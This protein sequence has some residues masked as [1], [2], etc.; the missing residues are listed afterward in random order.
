M[1][2][3]SGSFPNFFGGNFMRPK[4]GF[5]RSLNDKTNLRDETVH[6]DHFC[7]AN[8]LS[9]C[10]SYLTPADNNDEEYHDEKFLDI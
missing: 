7:I 9:V 6:F 4:W 2:H 1:V 10:D 5:Y 3:W 8:A